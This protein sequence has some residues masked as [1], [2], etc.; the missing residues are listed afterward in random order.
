MNKVVFGSG[1]KNEA[2][3]VCVLVYTKKQELREERKKG[4]KILYPYE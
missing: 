1:I 2:R 3:S 4:V